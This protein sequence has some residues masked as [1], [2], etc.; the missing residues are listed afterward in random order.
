MKIQCFIY[1]LAFAALLQSAV[2]HAR[3]ITTYQWTARATPSLVTTYALN[4]DNVTDYTNSNRITLPSDEGLVLTAF[5]PSTFEP[6]DVVFDLQPSGGST[7]YFL[8]G[9]F[10]NLTGV[11]WSGF[12]LQIGRGTGAN[13]VP[14]GDVVSP[15]VQPPR[16]DL[17]LDPA[18]TASKFATV[19][20]SPYEIVWSNGTMEPGFGSVFLGLSFSI[21]T[22]DDLLPS[23]GATS[24]TLRQTPIPVP[25]P[26]TFALGALGICLHRK[27]RG[28]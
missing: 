5:G 4:N 15:E 17:Q 18:P 16:F 9:E 20:T 11:S 24:F 28:A 22:P 19:A 25:E 26:S 3:T 21:D 8:Q 1:P 13:F 2:A 7:E 10:A 6:M 14:I 12:R 23:G 27:R